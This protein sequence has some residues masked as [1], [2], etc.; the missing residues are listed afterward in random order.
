MLLDMRFNTVQPNIFGA[1]CYSA[2]GIVF[3]NFTFSEMA[4]FLGGFSWRGFSRFIA[5]MLANVRALSLRRTTHNI[6]ARPY[7]RHLARAAWW[8]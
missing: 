4:F 8:L 5:K 7:T 1:A 2:L 6:S 3:F